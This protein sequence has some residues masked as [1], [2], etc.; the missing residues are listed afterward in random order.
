MYFYNKRC[1]DIISKVITPN[2]KIPNAIIP[3]GIGYYIK[4]SN[5][6]LGIMSYHSLLYQAQ[7]FFFLVN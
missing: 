1:Q 7:L 6:A 5:M 4:V 2:A 3:N